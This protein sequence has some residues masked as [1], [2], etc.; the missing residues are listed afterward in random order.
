MRENELVILSRSRNYGRSKNC[1]PD[2]AGRADESCKKF[3]RG[4]HVKRVGICVVRVRSVMLRILEIIMQN[5]RC[6]DII[7][8]D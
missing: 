1:R 8:L 6:Y 2:E 3:G 7:G 4:N 5:S